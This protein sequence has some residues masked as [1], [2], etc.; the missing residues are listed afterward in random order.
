MR[1]DRI[2]LALFAI[3][4]VAAVG[5]CP[6]SLDN[7]ADFLDAGFTSSS[8]TGS[9]GTGSNDPCGDVP[10]DILAAKCGGT[11][12]H[13]TK[14][15]QNGL[16]LESPGVAARVVGVASK[17]CPGILA[18][19]SDPESSIIYTKLLETNGCNARMP[20]ARPPL[21]QKEID[22]VK[23]WIGKQG[24]GTSTG[25]TGSGSSTGAGGAGGA[26]GAT[27]SQSST[28]ST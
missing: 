6:G 2:V 22:C 18:K 21:S 16:D 11:G 23:A 24:S 13:G 17:L 4:L 19:P 25:S 3:G 5:G 8:A 15:P 12:C 20:L 26:G 9:T 7:K 10:A 27:S 1:T 28:S 14:N